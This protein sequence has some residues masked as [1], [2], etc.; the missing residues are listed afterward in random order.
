[1]RQ[2]ESRFVLAVQIAGELQG[3]VAFRAIYEDRYGHKNVADRHFAAGEN[4]PGRDA[5]LMRAAF[6]L[7]ELAGLVAV[8]GAALAAGANRLASRRGPADRL[9]G[10]MGLLF[11][12]AGDPSEAQAS[13]RFREEEVLRHGANVFR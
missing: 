10:V 7:P 9:E 6:A 12:H 13:C 4:R 5:E 3:A 8:G 1:M 2:D 11:R